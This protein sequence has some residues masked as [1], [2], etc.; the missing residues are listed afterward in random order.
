M[1]ATSK[2]YEGNVA[3]QEGNQKAAALRTS[4]T[5]GALTSI[6]SGLGKYGA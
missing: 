2:E 4:A 1:G 5:M 3:I 6:G